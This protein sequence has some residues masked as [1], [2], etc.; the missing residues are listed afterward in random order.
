M[1]AEVKKLTKL[2]RRIEE[3]G[4]TDANH[5][6]QPSAGEPQGQRKICQDPS[7]TRQLRRRRYSS[8][9]MLS[10]RLP[11]SQAFAKSRRAKRSP[12]NLPRAANAGD[13]SKDRLGR[14][15]RLRCRGSEQYI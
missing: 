12:R 7:P 10:G 14:K 9:V 2:T 15:E 5:V 13:Y 8:R 11:G 1:P 3:R 4:I 6:P